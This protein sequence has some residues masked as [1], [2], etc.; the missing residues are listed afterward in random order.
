MRWQ[1]PGYEIIIF[2]IRQEFLRAWIILFFLER[3]ATSPT[4]PIWYF[5]KYPRSRR[6]TNYVASQLTERSK[7][8]SSKLK[9]EPHFNFNLVELFPILEIVSTSNGLLLI[10]DFS[11]LLVSQTFFPHV[12]SFQELWNDKF[13][14][15]RERDTMGR[16]KIFRGR[17]CVSNCVS[18]LLVVNTNFRDGN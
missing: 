2:D 15:K 3:V 10:L 4:N 8:L 1:Q 18:K 17:D 5:W 13:N 11:I 7:L 16:E 12:R 14:H 9:D 6:R